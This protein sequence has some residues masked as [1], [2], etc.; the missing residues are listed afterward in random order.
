M[1]KVVE[2]PRPSSDSSITLNGQGVEK[3][4][5][6]KPSIPGPHPDAGI[7]AHIVHIIDPDA[8]DPR[9]PQWYMGSRSFVR[10][11][12]IYSKIVLPLIL[13]AERANGR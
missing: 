8:Y 4:G 5:G 12:R 9:D 7:L 1:T 11:M 10:A 2:F 13:A 6:G 3:A